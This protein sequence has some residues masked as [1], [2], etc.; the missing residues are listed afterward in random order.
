M[1]QI[2]E[3]FKRIFEEEE[4]FIQATSAQISKLENLLGKNVGKIID[5]YR[6]Y[7]PYNMPMTESYVQLLDIDNIISE[8]TE[9]EPGVYLADFG[10]FC[11]AL[12]VGGNVLCIDTNDAKNGDASVLIA[13]A[14]FCSYNEFYNCVE[15]GIAPEEVLEQLAD[16]ELLPLNYPNLKKCLTK[17]EDSFMDFMLKL[18]ND[19]YEDMEEYLEE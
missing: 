4:L 3:N 9:A 2:V 6:E 1:K 11:F 12:T 10:V 19:E 14:N 18:S 5:F 15:I 7:Q 17:I 16:D 8:N 13:D